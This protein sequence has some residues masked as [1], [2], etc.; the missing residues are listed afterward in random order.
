MRIV[1]VDSSRTVLKAVQRMLAVR[2]HDVIPFTDGHAALAHIKADSEVAA[3]ITSAELASMTGIEMCWETRLIAST[4]RPIYIMLMSSNYD[5]AHL[6][7]AL[8]MGADDFIGKPPVAEEL[9]ARLRSAER[10]NAMQSELIRLATTDPLTGVRNRRAFFD[11]AQAACARARDGAPLSAVIF[12]I[13]HFKKINDSYGHDV[14]DIALRGVTSAAAEGSG[15]LARLGGEEFAIL[16]DQTLLAQ[17]VARAE[18]LRQRIA[19][20]RFDTVRGAMSLTCSFGVAEW[21]PGDTIDSLLKRADGAL[22]AA[23]RDG[24]NRVVTANAAA[25]SP[26]GAPGISRARVREREPDLPQW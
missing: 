5:R 2:G 11:W 1:L 23:K 17:A 6:A 13:D 22:Y 14:G 19:A 18:A 15:I 7:E 4:H 8:D 3:V 9:Y 21:Q 20:L 12:D 16:L 26:D 25:S 24:R 10:F